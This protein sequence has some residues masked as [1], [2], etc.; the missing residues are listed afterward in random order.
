M[1]ILY[2]NH[3]GL[4]GGASTSLLEMLNALPDKEVNKYVICQE[5]AFLKN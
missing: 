1:K 5:E 2:L 4:M 3:V